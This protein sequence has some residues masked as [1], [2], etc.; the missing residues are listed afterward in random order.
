MADGLSNSITTL[1]SLFQ[2]DQKYKVPI[3]QRSYAW[4]NENINDL[5]DDLM[6]AFNEVKNDRT[7]FLGT[8]VIHKE[9][10]ANNIVDGQQR[11]ATLSMILAQLRSALKNDD[12]GGKDAG[13]I[14][15][16][17]EDLLFVDGDP[18]IGSRLELSERDRIAFHDMVRDGSSSQAPAALKRAWSLIG[19]LQSEEVEG[20]TILGFSSSLLDVLRTVVTFS[21]L[22]V[23]HPYN[24]FTVFETLNSRGQDLAQSDLIKNRVLQKASSNRKDELSDKWERMVYVLPENEVTYYL[25]SWWIA[26]Q[27]FVSTKQLYNKVRKLIDS[28]DSSETYVTRWFLDAKYYTW[29]A[30]GIGEL[31]SPASLAALSEFHDLGFKQARPVILGLLL[32]GGEKLLP[33]YVH[34]L[35]RIYVRVLKTAQQRGSKFEAVLDD[36]S[37]AIRKSPSDGLELLRAKANEL[38]S[39]IGR[40]DWSSFSIDDQDFARYILVSIARELEGKTWAPPR[41]SE[42]EIEH[43]LP[44]TRPDGLLNNISEDEYW[45]LATHVGNL[46]LILK[47]DN[48]RCSNKL[49]SEKVAIYREYTGQPGKHLSLTGQLAMGDS[50]WDEQKIIERAR[51]L[52]LIAE[53]VWPTAV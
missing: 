26:Q 33:D 23:S 18:D 20:R 12:S 15:T 2:G 16:R 35:A 14:L 10:G 51:N 41:S 28:G 45:R 31:A 37:K 38:I 4:R 39:R 13:K 21:V 42:L 52:S 48:I 27:E 22:N 6:D 47:E 49:F 25:R 40:I 17:I 50:R 8:L 53:K 11:L 34:H 9:E 32:N 46:T 5:W 30:T 1:T 36:L 29:V 24:P 19:R 3:Y 7:L 43:I 44:R